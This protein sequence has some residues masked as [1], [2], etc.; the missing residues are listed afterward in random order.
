[1]IKTGGQVGE[2]VY[3]VEDLI[4]KPA[5]AE[6]PSNLAQ[7]KAYILTPDIFYFLERTPAAQGGEIWLADALR[8]LLKHEVAYAYEFE[9]QRYDAGSVLEYLKA[10]VDLALQRPEYREQL[11][12]HLRAVLAQADGAESSVAGHRRDPDSRVSV[13]AR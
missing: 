11:L 2:R 8:A 1:M 9:G 13:A 3:R 12:A 7:V 5:I 10:N 4:E 6:S